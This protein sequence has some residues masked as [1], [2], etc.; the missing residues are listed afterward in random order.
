M[1][2][3]EQEHPL[4]LENPN[5]F[6]PVKKIS[7]TS[8]P[9][10]EQDVIA[11]FNQLIAGG[12]IRGIKIMSTN[13]RMTYDSLY[14]IIITNKSNLQLF[15]CETNPL[16]IAEDVFEEMLKDRQE[17]V[18]EP[19][20]LEYKYSLD[21][22]IEDIESGIKNT[23]DIN[24]VVAWEAGDRYKDNFNIESLLIN[25]NEIMRQYHGITHRLHSINANERVCDLILLK[26]LILYLNNAEES[27]ELQEAYDE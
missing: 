23:S 19:K 18:S 14:K 1:S 25:G 21:G 4:V 24:L 20:V 2:K 13:E 11:L 9:T 12:V 16:G 26:D 8:M 15:D 3:H 7:I 5:F 22:L 6:D 17:F 27:D 10:R